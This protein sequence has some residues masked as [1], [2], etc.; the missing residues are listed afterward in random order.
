[1]RTNPKYSNIC[2]V[3][4]GMYRSAQCYYCKMLEECDSR[5]DE[6]TGTFDYPKVDAFKP[7]GYRPRLVPT[8]GGVWDTM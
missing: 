4:I 2:A 8:P 7:M 3:R 6:I 5:Y 1:M